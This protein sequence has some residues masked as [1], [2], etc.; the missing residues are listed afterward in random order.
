[1]AFD[2]ASPDIRLTTDHPVTVGSQIYPDAGVIY[3]VTGYAIIDVYQV[4]TA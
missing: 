2:Y 4:W 3:Y 1:L